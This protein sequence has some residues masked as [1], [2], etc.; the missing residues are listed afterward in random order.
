MNMESADL[1]ANEKRVKM[2]QALVVAG[3]NPAEALA[4]V[5]LDPIAHS[6]LPSV[7]LQGVAQIDPENP[8]AVYEVE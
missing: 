5:G 6:G 4:A 3:Y 8:D 1:I 7:Q 2:V